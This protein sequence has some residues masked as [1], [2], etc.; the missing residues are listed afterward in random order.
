MRRFIRTILPFAIMLGVLY[1]FLT[2]RNT[3]NIIPPE[4]MI[5]VPGNNHI[6]PFFMD[7]NP[8]TVSQFREFVKETGYKTQAEEFGD[9]GVF[10]IEED[11]H[12]VKGAFWEYPQGP[13]E[14]PAE[15]NHPVTQVSWNDAMAYAKW[16]GSRLPTEQEFNYA[17]SD[18]GQIQTQ[19]N[20]GDQ[21]VV[22][23]KF[24]AN[25]WQGSF[26]FYNSSQDGY[27]LTSPVGAFGKTKLGLADIAGN[28]WE[29]TQDWKVPEGFIPNEFQPDSLSEKILVG[30][31]FLCD[32]AVCH[33][34]RL[35][36]ES[37]STPET[38]LFHT[39]FRCVRDAK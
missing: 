4:G 29:W 22:N 35:E 19:Y 12:L 10:T 23:G 8:V 27:L 33:G 14:L 26:P 31:S 7:E 32:P 3:I 34:Y 17:A 24:M 39:G 37:A 28:V 1:W 38:S 16:K 25:T 9:A 21:L 5:F 15:D 18:A 6:K 20:W 30:G 36:G 13:D 2:Q 11:W